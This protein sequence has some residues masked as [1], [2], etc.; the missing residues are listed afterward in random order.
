MSDFSNPYN[1][2]Q[3]PIVPEKIQNGAMTDTMLFYLKEAAPWLRFIGVMGFIS[4]GF[5]CLGAVT[6]L[7]TSLVSFES[8]TATVLSLQIVYILIGLL[9][10]FP[11]RFTYLFGAKIRNYMLS[12]ADED[13]EAALRNNKSYWK[14]CGILTIVCLAIVPVMIILAVVGVLSAYSGLFGL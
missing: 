13:L 3:S 6:T 11:A 1:S 4:F 14:F 2:P 5:T 12:N 8:A 9:I 7:I 10:F